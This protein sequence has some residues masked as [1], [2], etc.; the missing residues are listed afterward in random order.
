MRKQYRT[1]A[2]HSTAWLLFLL[3]EWI[4]KQGVLNK[5]ETSLFNF[6]IVAIRVLVLIPAVYVTLYYLVP[7]FF[8]NG[9]RLAFVAALI[10]NIMV[11]TFVMKTL[12]YVLV[13]KGVEGFAPTYWKSVSGLTGWLIFMGNIAFNISFALMF[14]FINKWATDEKKRKELEAANKEA[15]L[16][17]LKSQVQPHFLFNTLNNIYA[18]SQKNASHTSEMIYRLSGLLEYMLYDSNREW[19]SLSREMKYIEHYLEIEK[20]RYGQRLDVSFTSYGKVEE[21]EV[22]PLILLPFVEN[23]FKHGFSQDTGSCWLRIEVAFNS[24]WLM[25]KVENSIPEHHDTLIKKGGLGIENVRKRLAILLNDDFELKQMEATDSYLVT[26]KLMPK[27]KPLQH[28]NPTRQMEMLG[29]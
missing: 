29:R 11:A 10:G 3:Y 7:Q 1:I 15:E 17:L 19:I 13:L 24:P 25:M 28:E 22:P 5:P 4:F 20:I 16:R 26:L 9:K 14:F 27:H 21:L 12:N 8:L 2:I 18:L 6:K 23:C